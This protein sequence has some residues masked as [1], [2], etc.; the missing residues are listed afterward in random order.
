MFEGLKRK[1]AHFIIR[2]KYLR[3]NIKGISLNHVISNSNDLFF[4]MPKNDKDFFHSLEILKYYQI[5]KK[6]ITLFLP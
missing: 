4:I 2:K 1:I 3:K 6:I 5:H